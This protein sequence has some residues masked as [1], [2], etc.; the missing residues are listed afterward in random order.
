MPE[1]GDG[2]FPAPI[3]DAGLARSY[4]AKHGEVYLEDSRDPIGPMHTG[5]AVFLWGHRG[6]PSIE[7]VNEEELRTVIGEAIVGYYKD[8]EQ[9]GEPGAT[10]KE[11]RVAALSLAVGILTNDDGPISG[12]AA[13]V[14]EEWRQEIDPEGDV[15]RAAQEKGAL[16]NDTE[17]S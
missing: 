13:S 8:L 17:E 3:L 5:T 7:A 15:E 1:E 14:L 16:F 4:P 10:R 11:E 12:P 6:H 9:R 2:D